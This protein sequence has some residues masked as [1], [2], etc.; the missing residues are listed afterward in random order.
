MAL[1]RMKF[2]NSY[3]DNVTKK[4]AISHIEECIKSRKIGH[5]YFS[6]ETT[7]ATKPE[8]K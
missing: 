8:K 6:R 2:M 7:Q 1:N 3:V 4:E 5:V